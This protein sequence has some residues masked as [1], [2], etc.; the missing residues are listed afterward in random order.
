[1]IIII[2]IISLNK[3]PISKLNNLQL[4]VFSMT[5]DKNGKE[6]IEENPA[7]YTGEVIWCK[8]TYRTKKIAVVNQEISLYISALYLK[9]VHIEQEK[10]N[11]QNRH[12]GNITLNLGNTPEMGDH[13]TSLTI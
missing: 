1:M 2:S 10:N 12:T 13:S 3:N 9:W 8:N 11:D 5:T 7:G 6:E 4:F